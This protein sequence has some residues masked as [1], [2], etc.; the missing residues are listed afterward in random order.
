MNF[1][2]ESTSNMKYDEK[3]RFDWLD[4]IISYRAAIKLSYT[5]CFISCHKII[6]WA[7]VI[8]I[9]INCTNTHTDSAS[10]VEYVN[11]L[12]T[13]RMVI[14]S[15]RPTRPPVRTFFFLYFYF[16]ANILWSFKCRFVCINA[17]STSSK[18]HCNYG[19]LSCFC[20]DIHVQPMRVP[21]L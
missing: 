4:S 21:H 1:Y 12:P 14:A 3:N 19:F 5:C 16:N 17:F 13:L 8:R 6:L 7:V 10:A 15:F 9:C 11:N 18:W 2:R 20:R